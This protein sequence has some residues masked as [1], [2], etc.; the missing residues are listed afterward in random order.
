ML[1]IMTSIKE[2]I[3]FKKAIQ[4]DHAISSARNNLVLAEK[5]GVIQWKALS[6]R[7]L[8]VWRRDKRDKFVDWRPHRNELCLCIVGRTKIRKRGTLLDDVLDLLDREI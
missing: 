8:R 6:D 7:L 1:K 5:H 2:K 4:R 3:R